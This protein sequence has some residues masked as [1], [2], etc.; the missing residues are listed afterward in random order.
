MIS[1]SATSARFP[2]K[3]STSPKFHPAST[4]NTKSTS[5]NTPLKCTGHP[6]CAT[7][8]ANKSVSVLELLTEVD[9]KSDVW[10]MGCVLFTL[11]FFEHPFKEATKLSI[12]NADFHFPEKDGRGI[13]SYSENLEILLRNLLTPDPRLRPSSLE[14]LNLLKFRN[15]LEFKSKSLK[16]N[17]N[18]EELY[19]E[20]IKK[21]L[22]MSGKDVNIARFKKLCRLFKY[23]DYSRL[24]NHFSR[25]FLNQLGIQKKIIPSSKK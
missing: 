12:I 10:M 24:R 9:A 15:Y 8:T 17:P 4:T 7:S 25:S 2:R 21:K 1:S 23:V 16:L 18:S 14:V 6:K 20:R 11:L 3:C 5:K 22:V 19:L 13:F